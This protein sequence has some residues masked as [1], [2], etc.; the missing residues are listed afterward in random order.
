MA[1]NV[2]AFPTADGGLKTP[3]DVYAYA[4][5]MGFSDVVLVGR[6]DDQG[7]GLTVMSN[8]GREGE[9]VLMLDQAKLM[10]VDE[11]MGTGE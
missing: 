1:D 10:V 7:F 4:Q 11:T 3:V 8:L 5:R 6:K 2:I 9:L